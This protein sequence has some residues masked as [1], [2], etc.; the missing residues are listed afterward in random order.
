MSYEENRPLTTA[1]AREF[2][3]LE[4][5]AF[6]RLVS[7]GELPYK[8]IGRQNYFRRSDLVAWFDSQFAK[9]SA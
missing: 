9:E 1:E 6:A 7:K 2:L 3:K 5:D 4:E 8:R